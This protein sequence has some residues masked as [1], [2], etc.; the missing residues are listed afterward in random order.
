LSREPEV[1]GGSRE[2][3]DSTAGSGDAESGRTA[4][5]DRRALPV[6][7]YGK[8]LGALPRDFRASFGDEA[9][10]LFAEL[11][12]EALRERGR[13]AAL[14]FWIWSTWRLALCAIRA[15]G[16]AT[17]NAP[18]AGGATTRHEEGET[19]MGGFAQDLRYASRTLRKNPGFA[20]SATLI[21]AAGIGA[22]TT[23]FS[24]VDTVVLRSLPYPSAGRLVH[25]DEGAHSYPLFRAWQE[26]ES[27]EGVAA[28]RDHDVDLT[29]E[30]APQ[31]LPAAA[32]SDRF[33]EM[34]GASPALGRLFTA[35]E[36]PSTQGPVVLSH[37]AWQRLFA[38]DPDVVGRSVR[39]DGRPIEVVG[40]LS[41]D[42]VPPD[43]ETGSRVDFWLPLDDGGEE[44]RDDH[45]SHTLSVVGRLRPGVALAAAQ[46]EVDAQREAMASQ[47]PTQYVTR[48]GSIRYTPLVEL[49]EA[50]VRSV[51][52]TLWL[53][54]GAVGM[55]LLIACANVANL[56]LARGTSRAR[57]I[58]LRGALGASRRRI[59]RQVLTESV[60]LAVA[61]GALGA[62]LAFGGV[63]LLLRFQPGG[64]PRIDTLAVDGRILAFSL[65]VSMGTGVL[66]GWLPA[67]QAT[68][69]DINDALKDGGTSVGVGRRRRR[70]R[71]LLVITEVALAVV[72]LAGG[73][74]LFRTLIAMVRVDP[75]FEV[76]GLAV[77]RL[78]LDAGYT[79]T[80]RLQ[81][82]E[83]LSERIRAL[84]GTRSVG[85]GPTIPFSYTGGSRCCWRTNVVGDPAQYDEEDRYASIIHPVTQSYFE[86]LA[87]PLASGREFD[88]AD[89]AGGQVA[90]LNARTA[91][92]L[93]GTEEVVGRTLMLRGRTPL[94]VVGV[95]RGVRHWGL[96]QEIEPAVYVPYGVFGGD[97][98]RMHFAVRTEAPIETVAAALRQA[99]WSV[100]G[101]L[102]IP[103]VVSM[104]ARVSASLASPRFL[105]GLVGGFALVALLLACGGVYGSMLYTVG[106]RRREM[107]IR[108]AL[109]ADRQDV[110]GLVL[111]HA[112]LLGGTGIAIGLLVS[113]ALSRLMESLLWGVTPTDPPT[114]AGVAAALGLTAAV[115][116]FLPA[117]KASRTDPVRTL[118]AE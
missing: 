67:L 58:A 31:R 4:R 35:S 88:A 87:A 89:M 105:S 78:S 18:M 13:T 110:I 74:L 48:D 73:G 10:R 36:H 52:R 53:L 82:T 72:L 117:W 115:A 34:L 57:E 3:P 19:M 83:E 79:P 59:M 20:L 12:G 77:L 27:M 41:E 86:T 38:G 68:R 111:R 16:E 1:D 100:D 37:G 47:A 66:F 114:Y 33:F 69:G 24:V 44:R 106:Q 118:G 6:R 81:F 40:V 21:L 39:I 56:F 107:G 51:S 84:P 92:D 54:F 95:V 93:Y 15:R 22:T 60:V 116:S 23:I 8:M 55:L 14:R 25:F 63:E 5:A 101:D 49:R 50:T 11:Y 17:T 90:I 2:R 7:A 76:E 28:A 42:F 71:S 65:F 70:A 29:G 103:E 80:G 104:E 9:E 99:V 45:G 75:G 102:P 113:L 98:D 62:L 46:A 30:G 94:E 109:G 43:I 32:V 91:M 64:I 26:L 85:A 96:D 61:G 97:F 108:L 112:S